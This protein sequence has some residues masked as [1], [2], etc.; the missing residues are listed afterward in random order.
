[1]K[2]NIHKLHIHYN[3]ALTQVLVK[4]VERDKLS[5]VRNEIAQVILDEIVGEDWVSPESLEDDW[6]DHLDDM[7]L[8]YFRTLQRG[9]VTGRE[10]E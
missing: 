9:V 4:Y 3:R 2:A 8:N 6:E 5:A 1:M 7:A 10:V